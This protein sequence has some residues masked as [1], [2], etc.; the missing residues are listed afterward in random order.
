[1]TVFSCWFPE[2][3]HSPHLS[4][5]A[6]NPIHIDWRPKLPDPSPL[7]ILSCCEGH[8]IAFLWNS[9]LPSCLFPQELSHHLPAGAWINPTRG[10]HFPPDV[11]V[12]GFCLQIPVLYHACRT[13]TRWRFAWNVIQQQCD[14]MVDIVHFNT[15]RVHSFV[16]NVISLIQLIFVNHFK[17]TECC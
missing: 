7:L 17:M 12:W 5:C 2:K 16:G 9:S 13:T 10:I 11:F 15:K 1:M 14:C 3:E 8:G 6:G 4:S